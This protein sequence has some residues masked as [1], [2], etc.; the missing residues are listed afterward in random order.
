MVT[1]FRNY[2]RIHAAFMIILWILTGMN[3][4]AGD[5]PSE[6]D[7]YFHIIDKCYANASTYQA[8]VH[9]K[10]H[11]A[12]GKQEKSMDQATRVFWKKPNKIL[13]YSCG[14]T[15]GTVL[16]SDGK[17]YI[18]YVPTVKE[19]LISPP[20]VSI[21]RSDPMN[22]GVLGQLGGISDIIA[23]DKPSKVLKENLTKA[24]LGKDIEIDNVLCAHINLIK[25]VRN[26]K[27]TIDLYMDKKK[28]RL[29]R[30]VFDNKALLSQGGDSANKIF[31]LVEEHKN[32]SLNEDIPDSK[33][34]FTP[35]KG[36]KMVDQFSFQKNR[37]F[38]QG[39][40]TVN[41][42]DKRPAPEFSL[43]DMQ[44][45]IRNLSDYKGRCLLVYFWASFY[46]NCNQD[47]PL[48][49]QI[50]SE[51]ESKGLNLLTINSEPVD[52][53]KDFLQLHNLKVTVLYDPTGN[54]KS[55]FKVGEIP[56]LVLIDNKG[57][58]R[59]IKT[60]ALKKEELDLEL[61]AL[62]GE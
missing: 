20:P 7:Q 11:L 35:P 13:T 49:Y 36:T 54:V 56:A 23:A 8:E 29:I 42:P 39:D 28:G 19:Y 46:K 27:T 32:A 34:E 14:D 16:V 17:K 57:M 30:M 21:R 37:Q 31:T 55:N 50:M 47:M 24:S 6:V 10:V 59:D 51:Y 1:Y 40:A 4:F 41:F 5:I 62:L 22:S 44:N 18:K 52:K 25:N 58:I 38:K 61:P 3:C 43:K 26:K 9:L 2:G 60:G 33:F 15:S 53:A 12:I 45:K 48:L